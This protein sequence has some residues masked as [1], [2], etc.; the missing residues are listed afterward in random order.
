MQKKKL[1]VGE[2]DFKKIIE[3]NFYY[4]DKSLFIKDILDKGDSILLIPRPRRFGKTL[5]L[6]M[7]KYFFDC[8]PKPGGKTDGQDEKD[9]NKKLF[10]S[11]S[12]ARSGKKYLDKMGKF[13]VIFLSFKNIKEF[14]WDYCLDKI[15]QLIQAEYSRHH[16]LLKWEG[17]LENEKNYFNRILNLTGSR[18]DYENSLE[19]LVVFLNRHYDERVVI[20]IDEYDEPVHAGY[21]YG[22]YDEIINF[23]RNFFCGGLK[24]TGQYLE[25]SVI[26]GIMRIARE[27]VFSGLN[28]PGVY[29]LLSAEFDDY[30]GFTEKEVQKMLADY[31]LLDRYEDVQQWYDGYRFGNEVIYNPWSLIN[32]LG[33]EENELKPYWLHTSDNAIIEELLSKGGKELEEEL[34]LLVRG[35]SIEKN[36]EESIVLKEIETREDLYWSFLLQGG[37]LKATGKRLSHN[38]GNLYY[39]LAIPNLE[40]KKIYIGIIDRFFTGK[41]GSK[42]PRLMLEALLK[43]EV[44]QFE[45]ILRN[46]VRKVFSYHD[47]STEPE[48]VYHALTAGILVWLMD[49]HE[50]RSNR[51]SG[52]GRYDIMIIPKKPSGIGYVIEFK[53]LRDE[54]K[55]TPEAVLDTALKQIEE[56]Q[57]ATELIEKGINNIKKLAIVFNGKD[58]HVKES[59]TS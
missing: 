19:K 43:G 18:A 38:T 2:S 49:T 27:S 59:T 33:S 1:P 42:Q 22:Y 46:I 28:N 51:E 9:S 6:S 8:C 40:V 48:K 58:V 44:L 56:K 25:K 14:T 23:V 26:T 15:K 36:I 53:A 41:V 30:F 10:D 57:Y 16:Y 13:P 5:N 17:L 32:F 39:K 54:Q 11:L 52:Y 29:T 55:E 31:D 34:E 21:N 20:L 7:L 3:N 50:I 4:V 37:Y 12:I 35:E 45:E 24:D 47:F